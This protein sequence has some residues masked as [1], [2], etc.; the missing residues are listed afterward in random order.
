M[1]EEERTSQSQIRSISVCASICLADHAC[2]AV[3]YISQSKVCHLSSDNDLHNCT[4]QKGDGSINNAKPKGKF[5][6]RFDRPL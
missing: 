2:E 5:S 3:T 4:L 6:I 1:S